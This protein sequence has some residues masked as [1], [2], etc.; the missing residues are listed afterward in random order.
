MGR[1]L[2]NRDGG[3]TD[4]LGHNF[5]LK[6]AFTGNVVSGFVT[7]QAGTPALSVEVTPGQALIEDGDKKYEVW[8]DSTQTITIST[9]NVS[10]PRKDYIVAYVDTTET[11]SPASP[12]N[13]TIFKFAAVAGTPAG[14]PSV[15]SV[16]QIQTAIG[17]AN[18][19]TIIAEV[20]VGAGVTTITNA[21]ITD[22]RTLLQ[23]NLLP[24]DNSGWTDLDVVPT[25]VHNGNRSYDVTLPGVNLTTRLSEGMR[26][27]FKRTVT[28]PVQSASLNGSS[29]Y[30][31]KSSPNKLTYA[32]D[33]CAGSWVYLT[34]YSACTIISRY[35]GTSG[36]QL[37]IGSD[38][39]VGLIGYNGGSGNFSEV[40][41]LQSVP[42]NK[43]V[44][45]S[46]QLDMSA[47]TA[48]TTTS[49]IMFDGVDVPAVVARGGTNPT[50]LVQAGNLQVGALNGTN[51]F[52]GRLAQ[53]WVSNAKITQA[54]AK[55]FM[56][57]TLSGT[58]TSMASAFSLS[59][60][61][62]DLNTTTPNNLTAISSAG[63]VSDSP[64]A[65]GDDSMDTA[66]TIEYAIITSKPTY[67][68]D[69]TFS[70]QV[71]SNC[72]LP[73]SG[74]MDTVYYSNLDTPFGFPRHK[75]K[76][77]IESRYRLANSQSSP[78]TQVWYAIL[79]AQI[80][81]KAGKW[82]GEMQG[83]TWGERASAGFIDPEV[84]LST[85]GASS[86][87]NTGNLPD[88]TNRT[89]T[90]SANT[91]TTDPYHFS[92]ELEFTSETRLYRKIRFVATGGT[93]VGCY[94]SGGGDEYIKLTPAYL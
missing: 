2:S 91:A 24:V 59:G 58:E 28:A 46:A 19:Y 27:K 7:S 81:A 21:N 83:S 32:D 43:W 40:K 6:K 86:S 31:E 63:Y 70:V 41:S 92:G 90:S 1:F 61:A 3:K 53:P 9:P 20:L 48:T 49:Y 73:T 68:T 77:A 38:G 17:A 50:A 84:T 13:P 51:F 22:H 47:F 25:V 52:K 14:S 30:F 57:Q 74:G 79:S 89:G 76:W 60:N 5:V 62:N 10:N 26:L 34:D 11:P 64:F 8:A 56:N 66:G 75:S 65:L 36:W 82:I 39:R 71:P 35:N 67:S 72:S 4:E 18:P 69:T 80:A 33:F 15:P 55:N 88:F 16:G 78:T 87:S 93:L 42:L 37:F 29:Q 85:N 12:N 94:V 44:Y 23:S 54:T 45:V